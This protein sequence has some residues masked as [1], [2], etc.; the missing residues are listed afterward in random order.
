MESLTTTPVTLMS[1]R[2]SYRLN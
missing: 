1:D 2:D